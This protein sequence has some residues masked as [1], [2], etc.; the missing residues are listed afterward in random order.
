[1]KNIFGIKNFFGNFGRNLA[2]TL[3]EVM[4]VVI[5][6]STMII[7]V[8][9]L[10]ISMT[11]TKA[12]VEA[13]ETLLKWSYYAM[14]TLAN[15][16]QNYSIDY[17]EYFNRRMVWCNDSNKKWDGFVWSSS[18]TESS[19]CQIPSYYWNKNFV[20]WSI[21]NNYK[22]Y[23]CSS[24]PNT[25]PSSVIK[26]I[27]TAWWILSWCYYNSSQNVLGPQ[28]FWQYQLNYLD[29]KWDADWATADTASN[30]LFDDDDLK[31]WKWPV[32]IW[33]N[34]NVKELYL[35]SKDKKYRTFIRRTLIWSWNFDRTW[36]TWDSN[37]DNLYT[38]QI[39]RL[40]GYD[41]WNNHSWSWEGYQDWIIDTWV[42]DAE[43]WFKCNWTQVIINW[44]PYNLPQDQNDWWV[45]ML[46][47]SISLSNLF[48]Q[49]YPVKDP[50]VAWGEDD[51]QLNPYF[52]INFSANLY[53]Q[54]WADKY[55]PARLKLLTNDLQTT[56]NT[57]TY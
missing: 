6:L 43:K 39:L 30:T 13:K 37:V 5:I 25:L 27:S 28:S 19:N 11:K 14:E 56:F 57:K 55:N 42:C 12:E 32:A 38:L 50:K 4:I 54:N 24:D 17:E 26:K 46:D 18:A 9:Q 29:V 53:G 21:D 41:A 44:Q 45:N 22:L 49:I 8:I 10:F 1:M 31:Q 34:T 40:R 2:F 36:I 16:M 20:A 51:M 3:V 7:A 23:Y 33:D 48:F 52:T 35:I 47:W 15:V